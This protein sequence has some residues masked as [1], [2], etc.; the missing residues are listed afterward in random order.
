[1]HWSLSISHLLM[2]VGTVTPSHDAEVLS[3]LQV[4]FD[5]KEQELLEVRRK[6]EEATEAVASYKSEQHKL[7]EECRKYSEEIEVM[8][9]ER[10]AFQIQL[11][12]SEQKPILLGVEI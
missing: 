4:E 9:K 3:R 10:D 7:I 2:I 5:A 1:M 6:Q 12:Q 8:K 11:E